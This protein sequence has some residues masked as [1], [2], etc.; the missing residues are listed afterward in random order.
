MSKIF[1]CWLDDDACKEASTALARSV[2][3]NCLLFD[4]AV[5]LIGQSV[6]AASTVALGAGRSLVAVSRGS[7]KPEVNART[8]HFYDVLI[9][10]TCRAILLFT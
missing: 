8:D 7:R 5:W 1:C 6:S 2:V 3:V 9:F 4:I 10:R